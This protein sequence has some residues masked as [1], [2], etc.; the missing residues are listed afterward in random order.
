MSRE[1]GRRPLRIASRWV[2]AAPLL[3]LA[4]A[5]PAG[6]DAGLPMIV[7]TF[8]GMACMLLPV[9]WMEAALGKARLELTFPESFRAFC[10]A[11]L[12][13]TLIGVPAAWAALVGLELAA[14]DGGK[15]YGV[16]TPLG[17][18]LAVTVQAPWLVPYEEE[19]HWMVP[20]AAAVLLVPFFLASWGSEYVVMRR[21]LKGKEPRVLK[22]VLFRVNVYS[23][24]LLFGVV[25][26][27][28]TGGYL[29]R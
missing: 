7:V 12:V 26:V 1:A 13:S 11:N 6:A 5:T 4:A 18:I 9:I 22:D 10:V 24:L 19:F 23:Y 21:L 14:T 8:P 3:M 15:A 29:A 17:K 16:G 20:A 28:G 2:L 27:L 25:L